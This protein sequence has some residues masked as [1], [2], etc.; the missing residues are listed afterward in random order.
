MKEEFGVVF[1][2]Y[3]F[4]LRKQ[5]THAHSKVGV[6][7]QTKNSLNQQSIS[8]LDSGILHCHLRSD[9]SD[10]KVHFSSLNLFPRI[11]SESFSNEMTQKKNTKRQ[12]F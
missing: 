11:F 9:S 7:R 5:E 12:S 8:V 10:I 2:T 1:N 6:A 4:T 3:L